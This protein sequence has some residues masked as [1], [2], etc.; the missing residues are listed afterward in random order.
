MRIAVLSAAKSIHTEKWVRALRQRG[1]EVAL[2][3]LPEHRAARDPG[4]ET[5]YLSRG[6]NPGYYFG[7]GELKKLLAQFRPDVL[8]AHYATGYG[9]LARRCTFHPLLLSVWGSDVYDFPNGGWI[10]RSIIIK[11]LR[12][13]DAIASTSRAMA[14]QVRRIYFEDKKIYITPFGVDTAEFNRLAQPDGDRLTVGIVKALEEKY[15]VEYLIRAF[16]LLTSRLKKS[17]KLLP[18]G[19]RLQIYGGGSL[20]P[21]LRRLA[22][23]LGLGETVEFF[24]PVRHSQVPEL[25]SKMDIF[26]CPSISDS[27]SFGVAAVEAMAC[28]V[29][30]VASDV[31]GFREVV[32]DRVT[33]FIV[34]RRDPAMLANKLYELACDPGLRERMGDAGR[35]HVRAHYEW[36]S[37]VNAMEKALAD[38]IIA[39]GNNN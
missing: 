32:E 28:G 9:T 19:A 21:R 11:N 37:C 26:C 12:A 36:D 35:Q 38:T 29:P 25:L 27:E 16:S 22:I 6:G 15:G 30:V 24:G 4:V 39:A 13:A 1:H 8:N 18:G 20:G 5:H 10:N 3:S 2:F 34:K 33:G 23:K 31:D 14:A 17:G 7:A